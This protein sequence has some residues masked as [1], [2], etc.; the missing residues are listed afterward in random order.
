M[1]FVFCLY[2]LLFYDNSGFYLF[3][4]LQLQECG[5]PPPEIIK[6][7]APG[8]EMGQDGMPNLPNMGAGIPNMGRK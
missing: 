4:C 8:L 5:Q 3:F 2:I 6:E 1:S 7:L